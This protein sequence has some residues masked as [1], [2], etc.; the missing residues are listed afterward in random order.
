MSILVLIATVLHYEV[1]DIKYILCK[2]G[3]GTEVWE[4]E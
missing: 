3:E 2:E 4:V 1:D